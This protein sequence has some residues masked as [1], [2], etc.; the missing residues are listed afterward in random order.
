VST[1]FDLLHI[2]KCYANPIAKPKLYPNPNTN[3]NPTNPNRSSKTIKKLTS[4]G[5]FY[6]YT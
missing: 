6:G 2:R 1:K 4:E 5:L 3:L